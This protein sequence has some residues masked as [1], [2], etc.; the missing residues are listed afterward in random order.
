MKRRAISVSRALPSASSRARSRSRTLRSRRR[1]T[2]L[3]HQRGAQR[4]ERERASA[5]RSSI[6]S[7]RAMSELS[8]ARWRRDPSRSIA[9]VPRPH[10][11]ALQERPRQ[12]HLVPSRDRRQV[13]AQDPIEH[14]AEQLHPA[15][16]VLVVEPRHLERMRR[17]AGRARVLEQRLHELARGPV[18]AH[19]LRLG[20]G[21]RP[22]GAQHL[23]HPR[24]PTRPASQAS[25]SKPISRAGSESRDCASRASRRRC[26]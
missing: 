23:A 4:L 22:L 5:G 21:D 15:L 20:L 13:E 9:M 8:A 24:Q 2:V 7:A 16:L 19:H 10:G 12:L 14:L 11:R 25:T 26:D 1:R 6:C 17:G 3:E 18:V